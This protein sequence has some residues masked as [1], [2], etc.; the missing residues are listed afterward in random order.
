LS[1]TADKG[2]D[3]G[4]AAM[5]ANQAKDTKTVDMRTMVMDESWKQVPEKKCRLM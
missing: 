2:R 3:S 4:N 1:A 5:V